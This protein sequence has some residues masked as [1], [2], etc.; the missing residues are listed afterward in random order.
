MKKIL[1]IKSKIN[2]ADE[3][4]LGGFALFTRDE[5]DKHL[6]LVKRGFISDEFTGIMGIGSNQELNFKNINEYKKQFKINELSTAEV[7]L[8]MKQF[9]LKLNDGLNPKAW[10]FESFGVFTAYHQNHILDVLHNSEDGKDWLRKNG[11]KDY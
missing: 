4:D 9:N 1:L 2:W 10:K 6:S 8:I 3:M 7:K 5:W 11:Y